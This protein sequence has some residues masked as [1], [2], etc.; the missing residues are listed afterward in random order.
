[1]SASG[2]YGAAGREGGDRRCVTSAEC[3]TM[4]SGTRPSSRPR[5]RAVSARRAG[6]NSLPTSPSGGD[7]WHPGSAGVRTS[8]RPPAG[9]SSAESAPR[10]RPW[11]RVKGARRW[12]AR[13]VGG[14][15]M[16]RSD[17]GVALPRA[18]PGARRPCSAVDPGERS[19][20]ERPH[21][22]E[23]EGEEGLRMA[24][25]SRWTC[26]GCYAVL[27]GVDRRGTLVVEAARVIVRRGAHGGLPALPRRASVDRRTGAAPYGIIRGD[28]RGGERP[29]DP[30]RTR[31]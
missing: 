27:G 9:R 23:G 19:H 21:R 30:M 10:R 20:R 5:R 2:G 26:P 3:R 18:R 8:G 22:A 28:G 31:R 4:T 25:P 14:V 13:D 15:C 24:R 29:R 7:A 11:R 17:R 6:G 12:L 16:W 1:M